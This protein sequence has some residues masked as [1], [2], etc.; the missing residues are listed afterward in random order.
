MYFP[1]SLAE[2]ETF[3][4]AAGAV[5]AVLA[6]ATHSQ[7]SVILFSDGSTQ[8]TSV[9]AVRAKCWPYCNPLTDFNFV[10][11]YIIM[12]FAACDG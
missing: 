8:A 9:Y 7:C 6:A 4:L 11:S 3:R 10:F 2:R 1:S 5:E 12:I